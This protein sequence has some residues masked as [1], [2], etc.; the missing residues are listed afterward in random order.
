MKKVIRTISLVLMLAMVFHTMPLSTVGA[1]DA[2]TDSIVLYPEY[3]DRVERDNMYKV[4]VSQNGNRYEIPVYNYQRHANH[5][6]HAVTV[7]GELDRRFCEF[8]FGSGEVTIEIECNVDMSSYS[9]IP[10]TAGI[11]GTVSGNTVSF[12]IDKP[13]QLVFRLNDDDYTNLA[14]FADAVETDVPDKN[15]S[16][17]VVFNEQ[18]P[19]PNDIGTSNEGSAT[20]P[21]GNILYFEAGWHYVQYLALTSNQQV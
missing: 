5:Y 16:N 2:Q 11:S 20:Y 14:I 13:Q 17:V 15:A 21:A 18:N 9:V 10:S 19:A 7:H 4:Y 8:S 6:A 3:P 12:T 1:V